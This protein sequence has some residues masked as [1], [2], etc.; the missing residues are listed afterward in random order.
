[1][2]QLKLCRD[3]KMKQPTYS[4]GDNAVFDARID[5]ERRV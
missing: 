1:M 5:K 4:G 2:S 3:C